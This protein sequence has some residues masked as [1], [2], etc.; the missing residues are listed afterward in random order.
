MANFQTKRTKI[1]NIPGSSKVSPT[2]PSRYKSWIDYWKSIKIP[3]KGSIGMSIF[4]RNYKCPFCGK[5]Y[6]ETFVGGHIQKVDNLD[7]HWYILPICDDCN[8]KRSTVG[9]VEIDDYTEDFMVPM[10]SNL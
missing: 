6:D 4:S 10:P 8:K 2:P 3:E 9:V 5:L 1:Q 7:R